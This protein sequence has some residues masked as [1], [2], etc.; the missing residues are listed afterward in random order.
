MNSGERREMGLELER[1][2]V[3]DFQ[4]PDLSSSAV[5]F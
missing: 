3:Y 5:S 4:E 2:S 1:A